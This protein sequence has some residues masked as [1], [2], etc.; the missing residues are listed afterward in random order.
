MYSYII[1]KLSK[2][3]L[4]E[5]KHHEDHDL[6]SENLSLKGLWVVLGEIHAL[7]ISSGNQVVLKKEAFN[8]FATCRQGHFESLADFKERFEFAYDNY[9]EQNNPEKSDEDLAMD[10][11]YAMGGARYGGFVAEILNDI[12]KGA[13]NQPGVIN[14]VF[15]LA[16]NRVVVSKH[17]TG[18]NIGASFATIDDEAKRS[19]IL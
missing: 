5:L 12:S 3:S 6:I 11:M 17:T 18:R 14:N 16:N 15:T 1:S 8:A 13:I 19:Q 2:E 4:D 7:N 10:F 9:L